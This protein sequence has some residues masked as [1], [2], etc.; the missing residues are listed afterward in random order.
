MGQP[1]LCTDGKRETYLK[2]EGSDRGQN[3]RL[4]RLAR[5]R[6]DVIRT[7]DRGD[8]R[9]STR[10]GVSLWEGKEQVSLRDKTK[11]NVN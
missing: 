5:R 4:K 7:G 2:A 11:P 8:E 1:P 6:I 3:K 10:L 9:K